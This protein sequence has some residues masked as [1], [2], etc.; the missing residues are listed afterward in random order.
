MSNNLS[1]QQQ[2][3]SLQQEV[4]QM[5]RRKQSRETQ[6]SYEKLNSDY[7]QGQDFIKVDVDFQK[8]MAQVARTAQSQLDLHASP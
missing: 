1:L 2:N 4:E 3:R 5:Q 6:N 7:D 8:D